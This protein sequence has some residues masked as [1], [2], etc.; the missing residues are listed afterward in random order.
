LAQVVEQLSVT[1]AVEDFTLRDTT[2]IPAEYKTLIMIDPRDSVPPNHL[3]KI[4]DYLRRGGNLLLAYSNLYGDLRSGIIQQIPDNGIEHWLANF[5]LA[6]ENQFTIDVQCRTVAIQQRQGPFIY[7]KPVKFPYFP[8]VK[9]FEEHPIT[10]GLEAVFFPFVSAIGI[11]KR[12][13][14]LEIIPI[15]F[16]S[17]RTGSVRAPSIID[18][19]KEW[20]ATDFPN[21]RKVFAVALDG[22]LVGSGSSKMVVIANGKFAVNTEPGQ[23]ELNADNVNFASNAIDWLSDDTGL[24]ELRTKSITYRPLDQIDD[25]VKALVKYGNVILPILIILIFGIVRRSK[26]LRKRRKLMQQTY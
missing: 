4:E 14:N 25:S 9:N 5:G 26:S 16:S 15:A 21:R 13:E 24:I 10:N 18:F 20:S 1:Y 22:P 23:E 8:I 12:N 17:Q 11:E 7:S 6:L 3:S 19:D 2:V